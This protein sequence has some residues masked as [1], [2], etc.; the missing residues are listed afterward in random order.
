MAVGPGIFQ[1]LGIKMLMGRDVE[2]ND[3]RKDSD[4]VWINNSLANL[5][6]PGENPVGKQV[7]L[8]KLKTIVGVVGDAKYESMRGEMLPTGYNTY[9]LDIPGGNFFIRTAGDPGLLVPAVRNV[10]RELAPQETV[11]SVST[12]LQMMKQQLFYERLMA[13]LSVAFGSLAL[14]LTCIGV[15][16]V[17]VYSVSRRTGEIAIRMALGAMPWDILRFV[18]GEGLRPVVAGGVLGLL[19]AYTLTHLVAQFLYGIRPLDPLT[20]VVASFL[21]LT[22]AAVACLIPARRATRVDPMTALRH[23]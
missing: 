19:G 16:G 15:Y 17:L 23:E 7:R 9:P 1:T 11:H 5:L 13:R 20:F 14:L 10:F 12:E 8:G 21:L 18:V 4:A 22:V 2:I 6:F 3:L